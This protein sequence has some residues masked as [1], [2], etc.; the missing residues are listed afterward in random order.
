M[1][2][3]KDEFSKLYDKQFPNL[4]VIGPNKHGEKY[5]KIYKYI[6]KWIPKEKINDMIKFINCSSTSNTLDL[7]R[8]QI[9]PFGKLINI[10]K[11]PKVC[12]LDYAN[13]ISL[14]GQ[15]ALRRCIEIYSQSTRFI[16]ITETMDGIID[17]ILSR[18]VRIVIQHPL[19]NNINIK[20]KENEKKYILLNN[21]LDDINLELFQIDIK[22]WSVNYIHEGGCGRD[23]MEWIQINYFT[24]DSINQFPKLCKYINDEIL[25]CW[26]MLTTTIH[27]K[28]NR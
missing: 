19:N 15:F 6:E 20:N 8:E 1:I 25:I 11:Y 7:V 18:C 10:Y 3:D 27:Q 9:K 13:T 21:L 28:K 5:N 4:L 26:M 22:E 12:I 2:E 24:L 14:D 23:L 16:L 17:P